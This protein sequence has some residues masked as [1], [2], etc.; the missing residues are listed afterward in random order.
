MPPQ[1]NAQWNN[2]KLR[3][4]PC[5]AINFPP[6]FKE[7]WIHDTSKNKGE[8]LSHFHNCHLDFFLTTTA[9]GHIQTADSKCPL[10]PPVLLLYESSQWASSLIFP[11]TVIL[12]QSSYKSCDF[13]LKLSHSNI[14]NFF[15]DMRLVT[16]CFQTAKCPS[17]RLINPSFIWIQPIL[18]IIVNLKNNP[19][20]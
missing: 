16:L 10:N 5:S 13:Y 19:F 6:C 3:W 11:V 20:I 14:W 1:L 2:K 4:R 17:S 12:L 8:P 9:Y 15:T 7:Y 18:V